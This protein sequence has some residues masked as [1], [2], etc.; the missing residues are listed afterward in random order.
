MIRYLSEDSGTHNVTLKSIMGW[1]IY[2]DEPGFCTSEGLETIRKFD[3]V[4]TPGRYVGA[5]E[6]VGDGVS[7]EERFSSL[8][9]QLS[10]QFKLGQSLET[11][12]SKTVAMVR[13]EK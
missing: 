3:H 6:D 4:L 11:S 5:A 9:K 12:I 10:V 7:F 1:E 13:A 8:S 2:G